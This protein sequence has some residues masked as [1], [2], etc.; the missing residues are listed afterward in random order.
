VH[1]FI[2]SLHSL[3]QWTQAPGRLSREQANN[4]PWKTGRRFGA[5]PTLGRS[6]AKAPSSFAWADLRPSPSQRKKGEKHRRRFSAFPW[7]PGPQGCRFPHPGNDGFGS[8]AVAASAVRLYLMVVLMEDFEASC[9]P[10]RGLQSYLYRTASTPPPNGNGT[11]E[12]EVS[13]P[14]IQGRVMQSALGAY[15]FFFTSHPCGVVSARHRTRYLRGQ[16]ELFLVEMASDPV[17]W[18][19]PPLAN[20]FSGVVQYRYRYR[21]IDAVTCVSLVRRR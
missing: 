11:A 21:H 10:T 4:T 8:E 18:R 7:Q 2:P 3:G 9:E 5:V 16:R 20:A 19:C 17:R 6:Q 14:K 1:L 13:L 12:Y 15:P